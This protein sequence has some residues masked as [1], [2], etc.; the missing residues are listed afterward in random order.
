MRGLAAGVVNAASDPM[1]SAPQR[2]HQ[3]GGNLHPVIGGHV[4]GLHGLHVCVCV[5]VFVCVRT[6]LTVL[7]SDYIQIETNRR[8]PAS[9]W[10][11]LDYPNARAYTHTL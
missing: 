2:T 9:L 6:K 4:Q 11:P 5:C 7:V 10:S 1:Q 3:D 8:V